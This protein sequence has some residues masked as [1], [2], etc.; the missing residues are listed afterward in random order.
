MK[1]YATYDIY[2][3]EGYE[4]SDLFAFPT[5]AARDAWVEFRDDCSV[6][7]GR[8]ADNALFERRAI[9]GVEVA[10]AKR[11][12]KDGEY[13]FIESDEYLPGVKIYV[14]YPLRFGWK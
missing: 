9:D 3:L 8:N 2:D 13:W 12:I 6:L 11:I 4:I 7:F 5:R 10:D 14:A 1:Y